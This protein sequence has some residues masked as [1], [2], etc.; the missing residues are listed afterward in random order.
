M[1][2]LKRGEKWKNINKIFKSI[3]LDIRRH[4]WHRERHHLTLHSYQRR[5]QTSKAEAEKTHT[6]VG[7]IGKRRHQEK[8]QGQVPRG[9]RLSGIVSKYH[10]SIKEREGSEFVLIIGI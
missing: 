9:S 4:A 8:Y 6:R 5:V 7:L 3:C 10:A 2:P 1:L